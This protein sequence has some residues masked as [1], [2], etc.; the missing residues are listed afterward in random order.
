MVLFSLYV[1]GQWQEMLS[2]RLNEL[3]KS[4]L[5]VKGEIFLKNQI[6]KQ[7]LTLLSLVAFIFVLIGCSSIG[8]DDDSES[9]LTDTIRKA[10]ENAPSFVGKGALSDDKS[11]EG[12][13]TFGVDKYVGTYLA[14]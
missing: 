6:K 10:G 5:R 3:N 13:R 2:N 4:L 9:I 12:E 1:L 8:S 14:E 7:L 11:L